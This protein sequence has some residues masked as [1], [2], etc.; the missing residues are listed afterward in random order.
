MNLYLLIAI[1]F[2]AIT[3]VNEAPV[4]RPSAGIVA[5]R[6]VQ[7]EC[8]RPARTGRASR[9]TVLIAGRDAR[10]V[11]ARRPHSAPSR[12]RAPATIG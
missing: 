2:G 4:A 10:R 9:P 6:E 7:A 11:R 5:R 8:G 12:P 3:G 1:A